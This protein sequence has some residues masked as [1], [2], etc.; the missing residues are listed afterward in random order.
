MSLLDFGPD[1]PQDD[2]ADRSVV[3][4]QPARDHGLPNTERRQ[5]TNLTDLLFGV[6]CPMVVRTAWNALPSRV[7]SVH[8]PLRS[9]VRV[10]VGSGSR[11][12]MIQAD[13]GRRVAVM[14]NHETIRDRAIRF[15]PSKS[16]GKREVA[17]SVETP[18][19]LVV[20]SARPQPALAGPINAGP[21]PFVSHY[22]C[23][24]SEVCFA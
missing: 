3:D 1:V 14:A 9:R 7:R 23:H 8:S 16:V 5:P 21:E 18:V 24:Y 22:L 12:Q 6:A 10:V 17:A 20:H 11:K 13:T 15:S 19:A 4:T 2:P